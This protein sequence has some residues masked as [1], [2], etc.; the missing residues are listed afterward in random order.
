MHLKPLSVDAIPSSL[1]NAERYRF[2][3]EPG[4]RE[5]LKD[6][7]THY[8]KAEPLRA[9]GNDDAILRWNACVRLIEQCPE[10]TSTD[11]PRALML[12]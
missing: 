1:V 7:L 12:E 6:A 2:L 8:G 3:N 9:T 10:S 4:A 11:D 5:W